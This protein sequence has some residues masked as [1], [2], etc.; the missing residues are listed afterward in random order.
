MFTSV[1][2]IGGTKQ[3]FE[4]Q[5]LRGSPVFVYSTAAVSAII[6]FYYICGSDVVINCNSFPE[7]F[8][9]R[10]TNTAKRW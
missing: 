8:K 10:N 2:V 9:V 1:A 6:V 5:D 3:A 4:K 7:R